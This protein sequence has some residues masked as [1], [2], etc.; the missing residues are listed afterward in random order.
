MLISASDGWLCC[1]NW[2]WP[3]EQEAQL[4]LTNPRDAF[5]GQSRPPNSTIPYTMY[6]LCNSNFVCKSCPFFWY[7]TSKN[8]V[9]LKSGSEVT[10]GHWK[11]Y[12]SI[13]CVWFPITCAPHVILIFA[14]LSY[15]V[16]LRTAAIYLAAY[17]SYFP[18]P[19]WWI[20]MYILVFYKKA[21][22]LICTFLRYSTSKMPWP[23][24]LG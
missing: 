2:L 17:F 4:M 7:S 5:R 15:I 14:K 8:V 1:V 23:W 13:D 11:W 18:L 3:N 24:K 12:H 19:L 21:L 22:S 6:I 20:K 16:L 9:T 10:Q